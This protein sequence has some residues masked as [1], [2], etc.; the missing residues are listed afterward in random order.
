MDWLETTAGKDN[1]YWM[2]RVQTLILQ[3]SEPGD[4]PQHDD[5]NTEAVLKEIISEI[6]N[7]APV[8]GGLTGAPLY[9]E[10]L[11]AFSI[12]AQ[13][14]ALWYSRCH[15]AKLS[16]PRRP[17]GNAMRRYKEAY[18]PWLVEMFIN[19][20]DQSRDSTYFPGQEWQN[21]FTPQA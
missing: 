3:H 8:A 7:T 20:T 13:I 12:I 16:D 9:D 19:L 2:A 18:Q 14:S 21:P 4:I 5:C 6:I 1:S 11:R 17:V 15:L 10:N